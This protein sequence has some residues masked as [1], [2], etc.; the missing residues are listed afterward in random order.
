MMLS[1]CSGTG[2][3]RSTPDVDSAGAAADQQPA[4]DTLVPVNPVQ[5]DTEQTPATGA[6]AFLDEALDL[7]EAAE[8]SFVQADYQET[9]YLVKQALQVLQDADLLLPTRTRLEQEQPRE[10]VEVIRHEALRS[11]RMEFE[12]LWIRTNARY[13]K[14]IP[15]LDLTL[16]PVESYEGDEIVDLEAMNAALDEAIVPAPRSWMEIRDLLLGMQRDGLIDINMELESYP[17]SAW[18]TTYQS[19][20][21]YTG[22][23]RKNFTIWLERSG[24]Y[25]PMVE[26][27]LEEEGMPR[28]L[29]FLCMIESGFSARAYSRAAATGPWQFMYYTAHKFGLKTYRSDT[30]LDERRDYEKSTRAASDYLTQLYEE[31]GSWP[32]AMAAYNSGE[33]RVRSARRYNQRRNRALDYWS[34]RS[35]LPRE[36]RNYVPYYLAALA[37]GKNMPRFGFTNVAFQPRFE[38]SYEVVHVPGPGSLKLEQVAEWIGTS[39][40]QLAELNSE[41]NWR[42]TP[43][44]GYDLRL[45]KGT[46]DAFVAELESLPLEGRKSYLQ[47]VIQ[48]G[49]TGSEIARKYGVAWS[50]IRQENGIT[51]D[52]KL[53]VGDSLR[54]PKREQSRYLTR[55]EVAS[56]TRV[57]V[58]TGSGT[59]IRVRVRPGDSISKF[60]TQYGVTWI[61]IRGWNN[62]RGNTIYAGQTLTIY[63]RRNRAP[64]RAVVSTASLPST[65]VYTVGRNDTLWDI[66]QRFR[67]SVSE[68]KKWNGLQGNTIYPGQKLIVTRAAAE[69]AGTAGSGNPGI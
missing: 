23:G 56:L 14:L 22:R 27:F 36:T 51:S 61:Q 39:E 19:V 58:S 42:I 52:R 54:I 57:R 7:I 43:D 48:R 50:D 9:E 29:V 60:A 35:R 13:D 65:G 25:R 15:Q 3:N 11:L 5:A 31:F 24:R 41:L 45:P 63:P 59:P 67:T 38:G 32:L 8:N 62:L 49:D 64:V 12:R 66:S 10:E 40:A 4:A 20:R 28:D 26:Q 1:G 68:L 37:I 34:I 16:D 47:H 30:F 44:T 2:F 6:R 53:R 17:D 69:A 33:G 21:Y 55:A 46:I 18:R